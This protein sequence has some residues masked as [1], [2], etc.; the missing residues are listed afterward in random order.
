MKLIYSFE[1]YSRLYE[2]ARQRTRSAQD[3]QIFEQFQ[4]KLLIK[5]FKSKNICLKKKL[6]LD[7]GC[8]L[9]G[10]MKEFL[11][12]GAFPVGLDLEIS[13]TITLMMTRGDALK[14]PFDN[15][16][17][18]LVFCSSLIEHVSD[19][20][21]LVEEGL[22]ITRPGG[23]IYISFPP[24]YSLRGGH[25]FSPFHLL[26]ERVALWIFRKYQR[27]TNDAWI[28]QRV[29]SRPDSYA[30]AFVNWGLYRMTVKKCEEILNESPLSIIDCSTKFS[31]INFSRVSLFKEFLTW[32]VQFLILKL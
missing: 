14:T 30:S 10:F 28:S 19:P 31:P 17:F 27:H 32:H 12:Y 1:D 6:L 13:N 15:N 5:Y 22:R 9:G 11:D 26:G 23:Y 24:F 4:C 2:L 20:K 25:Q 21:A 18:D 7:L 29:S 3:Y 16:Q 8:G